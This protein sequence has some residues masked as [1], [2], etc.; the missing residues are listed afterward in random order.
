MNDKNDKKLK[1]WSWYESGL[2][3]NSM[4]TN[5]DK[6][7]FDN[8][9]ANIDFFRGE[10][11]RNVKAEDMPKPVINIIKRVITFFVAS[12]TSNNTTVSFEPLENKIGKKNNEIV[13]GENSLDIREQ[14]A[15][16]ATSELNNIFEKNNFEN[17]I[18]DLLFD[19]A[20]TGDGVFHIFFDAKDKKK[21]A[22]FNGTEGEI[23]IELVDGVN[24]FFGNANVADPQK[25]PYIIFE[26][27]DLISNLNKEKA[28]K[29]SQDITSDM[30]NYNFL[31]ENGRQEVDTAEFGKAKC[32]L[33]YKRTDKGTITATKLTK[34]EYIYRDVDTGL[35]YMPVVLMNWEKQKNQYHGRA[36]TTGMI[37]NQIAI[38]KM[39]AMIIY[40][41][42]LTAFPPAVYDASKV[43]GLTNELGGAIA[44]QNM[45]PGDS[46]KSAVGYLE[47]GNISAYIITALELLISMTKET[48]GITDASLGA[49]DPKNTSAII[50]VQKA[51]VIPLENVKANL[52]E[53]LDSVAKICL[54]IIGTNYGLRPIIVSKD[55]L[56]TIEEFD[57]NAIKGLFDNLKTNVGSS[58]YW[59]EVASMQTLDNL[60]MQQQIDVIDYLERVSNNIIPK[61]PE[62]I[63]KLKIK[64][65]IMNDRSQEFEQMAQFVDTL[66]EEMRLELERMPDAQR[67]AATRELMKTYPAQQAQQE[68]VQSTNNVN[69]ALRSAIPQ[70]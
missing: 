46:I 59:S 62:L 3:Y 51:A 67:E 44:L 4:L 11:W 40:H 9:E 31:T 24:V 18:R 68:Q 26:Y 8:V 58:S 41:L 49:I 61:K 32:L 52:Y 66:P 64:N 34:D 70:E 38:N 54:D 53:S 65:G 37:P 43:S 17:K 36:V 12:I 1:E 25:Q 55:N 42:M 50:A 63:E 21:Y 39:F 20:N 56:R 30:D 23:K 69:Q 45:Q 19:A 15:D 6:S 7:Y 22:G 60:L 35:S 5:N 14:I 57:F 33:V 47:P 13:N 48:M 28:D 10:Q 29:K 27:R 2:N 16:I